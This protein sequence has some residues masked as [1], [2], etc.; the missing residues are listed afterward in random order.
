MVDLWPA[1][2]DKPPYLLAF[3]PAWKAAH[4]P[5]GIGEGYDIKRDYL[6]CDLLDTL[7]VRRRYTVRVTAAYEREYINQY[8]HEPYWEAE[9]LTLQQYFYEHHYCDCH[10]KMDVAELG[11]EGV[12]DECQDEHRFIVDRIYSERAPQVTL[13]SET[14]AIAAVVSQ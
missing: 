11:V 9:M 3:S 14:E 13:Y 2:A 12:G 8:G 7:D 4:L 5:P 6:L 1:D 10:R